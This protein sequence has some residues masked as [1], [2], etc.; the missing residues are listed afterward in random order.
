MKQQPANLLD[1]IKTIFKYKWIIVLL[2]AV[3]FVGTALIS[4]L[5]PNYYKATTVFFAASE[6]LAKPESLFS[7]LGS[8][9]RTEYYGNEN[10][11]DRLMTVAQSNELKD[12]LIDT[13]NLY[14]HYKINPAGK[15]ARY[16]ARLKISKY[17]D[18]LKT[19]R[20][21]LELSFEDKS[22]DFAAQVSNAAR[23]K[24]ELIALQLIRNNQ[25]KGL[26]ANK[27]NLNEKS[28]LQQVLADS[29]TALRNAYG[30]FDGI[31]QTKDLA[32]LMIE[33]E[34]DLTYAKARLGQ[35]QK[36][37]GRGV[38]DSIVY[39]QAKVEGMEVTLDTL[40]KKMIFWQEGLA[41]VMDT[42][43]QYFDLSQRLSEDRERTR[44]LQA[45]YS[46]DV[47][48]ILLV[49][50]AEVPLYKSRPKRSILVLGATFLM[51]CF[52][53]LGVV[54]FDNYKEVDW[55]SIINA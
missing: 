1:I 26:Q 51:F 41:A 4:L 24:I 18:I 42:E 17:Y 33:M 19:D 14:E 47:P 16:K 30:V 2:C 55:K 3:T 11:I 10:D 45:T 29:L 34:N 35:Y 53:V 9:I 7:E 46:A 5:L 43:K 50:S 13:F 12:F 38:R 22:P 15:K 40:N 6:D 23:K 54:V 44:I 20:D 49:E 32:G 21:A 37:S 48:A 28:Q 8:N 52:M 39:L 36:L 27:T 31:E 25:S